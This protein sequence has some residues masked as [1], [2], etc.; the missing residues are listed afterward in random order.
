MSKATI[1]DIERDAIEL[2][3]RGGAGMAP[4]EAKT[5]EQIRDSLHSCENTAD[6]TSIIQDLYVKIDDRIG[7]RRYRAENAI[8]TLGHDILTKDTA[9]IRDATAQTLDQEF[10]KP[11]DTPEVGVLSLLGTVRG[12]F[13]MIEKSDMELEDKNKLKAEILI[14]TKRSILQM[15]QDS[16]IEDP[17]AQIEKIKYAQTQIVRTLGKFNI[18]IRGQRLTK[19]S[20]IAKALT[21]FRD[22]ANIKY[23]PSDHLVTS[24]RGVL[25]DTITTVAAKTSPLSDKQKEDLRSIL[26]GKVPEDKKPQWYKDL[27][28]YQKEIIQDTAVSLL[29]GNIEI[30]TSLRYMPGARN[31]YLTLAIRK[32]ESGHAEI[33]ERHIRSGSLSYFS[34]KSKEGFSVTTENLQ[35]IR[36]AT[37]KEVNYQIFNNPFYGEEKRIVTLAREAT[38]SLGMD[39]SLVPQETYYDKDAMIYNMME[40][41]TG[42]IDDAK[43]QVIACK[44]GKDR[45]EFSER[46]RLLL[47]YESRYAPTADHT[48]TPDQKLQLSTQYSMAAHGASIASLNNHGSYGLKTSGAYRVATKFADRIEKHSRKKQNPWVLGQRSIDENQVSK[49]NKVVLHKS[50]FRS[51]KDEPRSHTDDIVS[52]KILASKIE[53]LSSISTSASSASLDTKM[54]ESPLPTPDRKTKRIGFSLQK[55]RT[56]SKYAPKVEL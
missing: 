13:E 7:I 34:G 35:H 28:F 29:P 5:F 55:I 38:S 23:D 43:I 54:V 41:Q 18:N 44:S 31:V 22:A 15:Y 36:T 46:A 52:S 27:N 33:F 20:Q 11:E 17:S 56:L 16:K 3:S 26:S 21:D 37:A 9:I 53:G 32:D 1:E 42:P 49:L 50:L 8:H 6:I 47:A 4:I 14:S 30:P 12:A 51:S 40:S 19:D 45:T 39:H 24:T 2:V 48:L 10:I 25:G